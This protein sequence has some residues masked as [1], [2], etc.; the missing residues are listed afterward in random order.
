MCDLCKCGDGY[1]C[2]DPAASKAILAAAEREQGLREAL[3]LE[4]LAEL[5][6]EQW[7][8][9]S[10]ALADEIKP[11]RLARWQA[12]WI[13]YS[14]LSEEMKGHDRKWARKIRA[15]AALAQEGEKP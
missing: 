4:A 11:E 10:K 7:V 1:L 14:E 8:A 13:P 3:D 2:L 5:E 6:H 15:R 9:W 12:L